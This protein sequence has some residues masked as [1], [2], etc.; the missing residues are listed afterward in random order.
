[1]QTMTVLTGKQEVESAN[2]ALVVEE[3]TNIYSTPA[4][5]FLAL[6]R[7]VVLMIGYLLQWLEVYIY[8]QGFDMTPSRI[9]FIT[10]AET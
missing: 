8:T 4:P 10:I 9:R 7:K 1:M 6:S 2:A 3:L 5:R